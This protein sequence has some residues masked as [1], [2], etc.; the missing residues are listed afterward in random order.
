MEDLEECKE[1][2]Q[3]SITENAEAVGGLQTRVETNEQDILDLEGDIEENT[4]AI[5]ALQSTVA[6]NEETAVD[7]NDIVDDL[8]GQ[9]E[10]TA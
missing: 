10:F 2:L 5:E 7:L 9:I 6:T 4:L 8:E 3:T 1:T